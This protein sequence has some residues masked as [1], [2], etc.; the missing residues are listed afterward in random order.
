M[1]TL[2]TRSFNRIVSDI[3]AGIQGRVS[4]FLT[5]AIGSVFRAI[6]ESYAGVALWLQGLI[7]EVAKLT[8]LSTSRGPD[9]DS[10]IADW[11]IMTRLAAQP[12]TGLLTFSRF[13]A[14]GATPEILVGARVK[15]ADNTQSFSRHCG[16]EQYVL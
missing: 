6:A 8:R 14:S 11:G 5:F 15:T 4:S 7:L 2:P 9:V 3:S 12:A 16:H 13:T 10:W 1:A